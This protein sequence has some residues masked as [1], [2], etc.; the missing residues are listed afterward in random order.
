M[1]APVYVTPTQWLLYR[2]RTVAIVPPARACI[3][4]ATW[5]L[6]RHKA[7][8][9]VTLAAD[10]LAAIKAQWLATT[11]FAGTT[12]YVNRVSTK[13]PNYPYVVVREMQSRT[14]KFASD[15]ECHATPVRF[16]VY[17]TSLTAANAAM[18]KI[19][20]TFYRTPLAFNYG[21]FAAASA[22]P[23]FVSDSLGDE[24]EWG[25]QSQ[26]LNYAEVTLCYRVIIN[27][28]L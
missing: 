26:T 6:Y 21:P 5:L 18:T 9:P 28:S 22:P 10:L 20:P 4:P 7:P 27:R 2:R 3:T 19:W 8:A 11:A 16:R 15:M 23:Y 24:R 25:Q 13:S 17:H 1:P 12:F 14:E